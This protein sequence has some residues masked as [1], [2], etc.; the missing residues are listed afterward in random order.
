M[1]VN[2]LLSLWQATRS[3]ARIRAYTSLAIER[4]AGR[5]SKSLVYWWV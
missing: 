2:D 1:P 4:K 5:R 3:T